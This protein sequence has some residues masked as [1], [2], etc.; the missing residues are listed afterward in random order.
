M[1]PFVVS[2][3][4]VGE[5][6][7][8]GALPA[9]RATVYGLES[10]ALDLLVTDTDTYQ[11]H[12]PHDAPTGCASLG[13]VFRPPSAQWLSGETVCVGESQFASTTAQWWKT[14]GA[15]S[16]ANWLWVDKVTQLP[17]RMVFTASTP[18]PAVIGS[19][20]MTHFS[21]FTSLPKTNLS[22]LRDFCVAQ[23]AQT[24]SAAPASPASDAG[25]EAER[26]QRI[27]TL[28]PG[29]SNEACSRMSQARWPD[30]FV[31]S[32]I[33]TPTAFDRNL[34]L[35]LI[36][37]DW[38]NAQTQV[39]RMFQG[40]PPHFRGIVSLKRGV[41]YRIR[42]QP[43][44][45]PTCEAV[46]PGIVRPDWTTNAWC[47]C[48]GVIDRNPAL[49]PNEV[50]QVLACPIRLQGKRVMWSWFTADGRPALFMEAGAQG[51]GV[52][53]ADYHDWRPGETV[54]AGNFDLPA[55]CPVPDKSGP[56]AGLHTT[57]A[58]PS[59]NDCHTSR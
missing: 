23:G 58:N 10:G 41:G 19:Y 36:Y 13:R 12:G 3:L 7:Y 37:Y 34:N 11:L 9:M 15:G 28:V 54:A 42:Q 52:M 33:L 26:L 24:A 51:G 30:Q 47:Q 18:D 14:R 44:G 31:M 17:W 8:D 53:L 2:Q 22:R 5:F 27:A 40:T 45:A 16:R 39:A 57:L 48:K 32:L 56:P 20:A 6:V 4:Y 1:S 25:G 29:L 46:F 38:K 50:T 21:T 35:S 59:C 55:S 49:S 43:T